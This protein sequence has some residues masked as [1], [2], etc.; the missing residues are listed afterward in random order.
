[1]ALYKLL[2]SFS[3]LLFSFYLLIYFEARSHVVWA[4]LKLSIQLKVD[5]NSWSIKIAICVNLNKTKRNKGL[6]WGGTYLQFQHLGGRGGR[7]WVQTQPC[8]LSQAQASQNSLRIEQRS[9]KGLWMETVCLMEMVT[10]LL[11]GP[12]LT[13][14]TALMWSW[15]SDQ[16]RS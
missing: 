12:D 15:G 8:L 13:E 6:Q 16:D 2:S 9:I 1:M 4:G 5:L 7:I 3:H 14:V 11:L 10:E